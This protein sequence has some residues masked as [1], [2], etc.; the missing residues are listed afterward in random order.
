VL[1]KLELCPGRIVVESGTGSGSLSHS[2]ATALAP[3][4]HLYTFEFHKERAE[5]EAY[6][7]CFFILASEKNSGST[8]WGIWSPSHMG[9][10]AQRTAFLLL[11]GHS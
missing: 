9:T 4:G 8:G 11:M 10:R 5:I 6:F 1:S 7:F 2:I 3:H